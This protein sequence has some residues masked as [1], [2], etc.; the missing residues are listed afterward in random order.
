MTRA[1]TK[2]K[3]TPT[4]TNPMQSPRGSVPAAPVSV[5]TVTPE[6]A[7]E[8]IDNNNKRNRKIRAGVVE[9]YAH[10]MENGN[11]VYN[12]EAIQFDTN[13]NLMNGQ[14]RL[15]AIIRSGLA[16]PLLIVTGLDPAAHMTLDNGA[17]RLPGDVLT[18][19]GYSEGRMLSAV[20]NFLLTLE[21]LPSGAPLRINRIRT[22]ADL[23]ARIETD[24]YLQHVVQDII[25]AMAPPKILMTRAVAAYCYYVLSKV[26]QAACDEFFEGLLT[27]AD[28][29]KGSPIIALHRRLTSH[30]GEHIPGQSGAFRSIAYVMH[31]WNA[32][33]AGEERQMIKLPQNADGRIRIAHPQ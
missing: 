2:P 13:N 28:L 4:S 11:W 16:Q 21:A 6:L 29:P 20:A 10:D 32:W 27:L 26:D 14:H 18:I 23:L 1:A 15:K 8:W 33:R 19:S 5:V 17:R 9:R 31:A 3:P 12:G 22:T 25:P 7:E 30:T 24:Q